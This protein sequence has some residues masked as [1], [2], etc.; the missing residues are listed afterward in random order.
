MIFLGILLL[1]CIVFLISF[2]CLGTIEN[3]INNNLAKETFVNNSILNNINKVDECSKIEANYNKYLSTP[4]AVNVPNQEFQHKFY[5]GEA[6]NN[7]KNGNQLIIDGGYCFP[8]KDFRYDGVWT[9][10]KIN[11]DEFYFI[12]CCCRYTD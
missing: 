3:I 10:Y 6:N 2:K 12:W 8:I 9:G 11:N 1:L 4:V 7:N 5:I